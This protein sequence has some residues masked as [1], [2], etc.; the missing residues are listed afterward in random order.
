[1]EQIFYSKPFHS[2]GCSIQQQQHPIEANV[3]EELK[4]T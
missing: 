3:A 1:M 4:I 2:Q